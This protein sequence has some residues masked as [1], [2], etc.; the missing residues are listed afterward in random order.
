YP[1]T[2][3]RTV[4]LIVVDK[5]WNE[6]PP[7]EVTIKPLT[8]SIELIRQT[9]QIAPSFG[10]MYVQ[11]EN[12]NEDEIVVSVFER[13]SV[14]DYLSYESHYTRQKDGGVAFR[15]FD[16]RPQ[17]VRLELRDRWNNYSKPLDTVIT[18]L[19]EQEI[20]GRNE[21]GYIW[22]RWGWDNST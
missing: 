20:V 17:Q 2:E 12:P 6:S 7:V 8:P 15:G 19:F 18:P 10:G 4:Q 14:G 13:D 1:D 21:Q 16:A 3:Q 11:W 5:S 9:L 22:K